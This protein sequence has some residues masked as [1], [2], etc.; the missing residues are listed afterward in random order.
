MYM[1]LQTL[2]TLLQRNQMQYA[3]G[4]VSVNLE[5]RVA[6]YT[7][8][9]QEYQKIWIGG[10]SQAKNEENLEDFNQSVGYM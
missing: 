2:I 8:L 4:N 9:K 3:A 5:Q 7:E 1:L 6:A 10:M